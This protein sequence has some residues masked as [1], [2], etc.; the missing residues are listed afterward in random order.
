LNNCAGGQTPWGTYLTAEENFHGY[1]WT[2]RQ[3]AEN[4][5]VDGL[6]G[7][8]AKS[9]ARYGVRG[10]WQPWGKFHD[11]FNVDKE[12]N[13]P[14]R[15]GWIV[16]I[17]PSDPD[18]TPVKHTALGRFRHEGAE[19]VVNGDG[20]VVV[21]SS[22]DARFDYIYRFVSAGRFDPEN[23]AHNMQLLSQGTPVAQFQADGS[24]RWLPL[25]FG[26]GP[27]T[28]ENGCA[29]Q[30]DGRHR[31]TS[32]RGFARRHADG[33]AG[34]RAAGAER[35]Y[36]RHPHQQQGSHAGAGGRRQSARGDLFGHIIEMTPH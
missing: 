7:D 27:L 22:D 31:C 1:F 6:G 5:A 18:S 29:S 30:A 13:E 33:P 15:F 17:D 23:R 11:R 24:L 9:Y 16:E 21:Y 32:C 34:G 20:R 14:N 10:L 26:E 2:D 35:Q 4:R 36:L 3:D 28:E 8:Q 19:M 25:V 12:P